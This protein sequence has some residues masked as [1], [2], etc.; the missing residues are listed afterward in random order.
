MELPLCEFVRHCNK[1]HI[2]LRLFVFLFTITGRNGAIIVELKTLFVSN[3]TFI[4]FSGGS[5]HYIY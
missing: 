3:G 5:H 4:I 2:F 1:I